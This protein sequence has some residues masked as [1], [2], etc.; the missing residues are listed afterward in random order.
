MLIFIVA[1]FKI[2][3]IGGKSDDFMTDLKKKITRPGNNTEE[4]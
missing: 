4:P 3:P 1:D 2:I